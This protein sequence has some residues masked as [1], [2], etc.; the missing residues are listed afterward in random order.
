MEKRIDIIMIIATYMFVLYS[1]ASFAVEGLTKNI[2]PTDTNIIIL[3]IA[4]MFTV[5]VSNW[6]SF[7]VPR[8]ETMWANIKHG[9]KK[10][11]SI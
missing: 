8:D 9:I 7:Y 1:S 10:W 6:R 11:V 2:P 3:S 4:A 5:V